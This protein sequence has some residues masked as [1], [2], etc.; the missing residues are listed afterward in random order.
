MR[1]TMAQLNPVIGDF[2]ANFEKLTTVVKD[3]AKN[4]D[5]ILFS[6]LYPSGYPPRDWLCSRAFLTDYEQANSEII[7]FSRSF[8]DTALLF[9]T[10][11][12][13]RVK[14][15]KGLYNAAMLVKNGTVIFKQLKS[16]LPSYDIFDETRYFDTAPSVSNFRFLDETLGI[17]ICEDA[18][19]DDKLFPEYAYQFNPVKAAAQN[20][21]TFL[22]NISASPYSVAKD[23][24]RH[25]LFSKHAKRWGLPF[26]LLN[27]TGGNDELICDG[28]SMVFD[29]QGHMRLHM[30]PFKENVLTIDSKKLPEKR[31]FTPAN[32]TESVYNALIAGIKDYMEKCGFKKAVLGLSGGI[33]SALTCVLAARALGPENV[34]A[35]YMP[36]QYSS[37]ASGEDA[38]IQK[39]Y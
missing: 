35:V 11:I 26:L 31:K 24:I 36:S 3:E 4:T 33:D 6:E 29:N 7:G 8:P 18:W 5:I 2:K 28:S 14:T 39:I 20:G 16:L 27:Q 23:A 25:E 34:S 15:G 1:I 9:G 10:I 21:A 22:I 13:S 19:N 12:P 30:P 38:S 32:Q 37:E 17:L